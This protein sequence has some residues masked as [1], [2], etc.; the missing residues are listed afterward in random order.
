ME[1][2]F[3]R[4]EMDE[5]GARSGADVPVYVFVDGVRVGVIGKRSEW[6]GNL[7]HKGVMY[8]YFDFYRVD[9]N[10]RKIYEETQVEMRD[11][12]V[13]TD[14]RPLASDSTRYKCVDRA[15]SKLGVTA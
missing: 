4:D 7:G 2:K 10:G 13:R 14:R 12:K 8:R 15:L 6:Y 1:I 5:S 11:G 3:K 9:D